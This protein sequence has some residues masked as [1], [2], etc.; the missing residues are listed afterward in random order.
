[1]APVV[2][3]DGKGHLYGR[4]ASVIAKQLLNGQ[5]VVVVRCEA[6]VISGSMMRNKTK[7]AQFRRLHMNTNPGRGPFHFRSPARMLW[8]SVRGMIPHKTVRGQNALANLACFE[9]IPAPYDT[10]KRVAVPEAVKAI[11]LGP[12]RSFTVI[13]DLCK[14]V[15]WGY[16]D[17]VN[18]LEATR[19]IKEQAFYLE[20][21]QKKI[22]ISNATKAADLSA[23]TPV[24]AAAGYA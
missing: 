19:K 14:E 8:R 5:K 7:Y 6:I 23:I 22:A 11:N 4:M 18:K 12:D 17:L 21:K 3:V 2:V 9:G 16:K 1:M 24:L 15:G 20:K 13:G 10:M